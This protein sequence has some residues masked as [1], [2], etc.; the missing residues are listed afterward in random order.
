MT[1]NEVITL[2]KAGELLQLSPAIKDDNNV[3]VGFINLGMTE[4]YK[5]FTLRTEEAVITLQDGKTIYKLDGTDTD[6]VLTGG[7]VMYV[8]AA[9]GDGESRADYSVDDPILPLN[10]E[11]NPYSINMIGYDQVQIPLITA[12]A[13]I[14]LIYQAFP[15]K[16]TIDTLDAELD[17]PDQFVEPLLHYMGY[18]GHGSMDG[19]IQTESNTHYMRF[20]AS[21]DKIR[22]L[23]VG[24]TSD[25]INMDSRISLRGF[26]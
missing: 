7:K 10:V 9:Y 1:A 4:L 24:I 2:A 17:I 8:I 14:S 23:G 26:V 3:L 16:V 20:E 19:E 5:R 21:C 12:S 13:V 11:D 15:T 6:V 25:D 22:T 18:R